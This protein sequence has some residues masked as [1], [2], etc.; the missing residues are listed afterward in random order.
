MAGLSRLVSLMNIEVVSL[1][2][3][4]GVFLP[5]ATQTAIA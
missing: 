1:S 4:E 3:Q 2:S 5:E